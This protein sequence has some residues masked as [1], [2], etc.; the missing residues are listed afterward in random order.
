MP[1]FAGVLATVL[2]LSFIIQALRVWA[3]EGHRRVFIFDIKSSPELE[4]ETVRMRSE[5][6]VARRETRRLRSE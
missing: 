5:M 6:D 3:N 2:V 1:H 4:E